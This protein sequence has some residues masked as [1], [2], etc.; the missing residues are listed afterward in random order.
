MAIKTENNGDLWFVWSLYCCLFL[1]SQSNIQPPVTN[2]EDAP[3]VHISDLTRCFY[4]YL[5]LLG[6]TLWVKLL[7][8][9]RLISCNPSGSTM[10]FSLSFSH[11]FTSSSLFLVQEMNVVFSPSLH[12]SIW[13]TLVSFG[14][15]LWNWNW[16]REN[17]RVTTDMCHICQEKDWYWDGKGR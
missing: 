10:T 16:G 15:S 5:T 2:C 4:D 17:S 1:S 9:Y 14:V 12:W 3:F 7:A 11:G 6:F 8:R 13:R